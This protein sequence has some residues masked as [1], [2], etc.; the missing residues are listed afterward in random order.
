MARRR[1][2]ITGLGAVTSLGQDVPTL[3]KNILDG[4]SG[5]APIGA[6]DASQHA[7]RIASEVRGFDPTQWMDPREAKRQDRF[8]QFAMA[9][10]VQAVE[11]SG[12]D[13]AKEDVQRVGVLIGT[14]IG[15]IGELEQQHSRLLEGGPRRVS[16]FLIPKL[17]GNAASGVVSIRWGLQGPNSTVVTACA[18]A[19]HSL[20]A[21]LRCIQYDEADMMISGG[22]EAAI[23]ALGVAGF[24]SM[25][26]LSTRNDD[27][28][29]ASRPFDKDRDGFVIAEGAGVVV[30]EELEHAK[31]RGASIYAEVAGFAATGDAYH[32]TAPQP[33]GTGAAMAMI[34]ALHDAGI[35]PD[36]VDYINAHGTSTPLND[37]MESRAIRKALGGAADKVAVSS[38][39][40]MLGHM[41]GAAGGVEMIL[42]ALAVRDDVAPP[43]INYKTPDP[44][45]DLYYVPNEAKRMTIT[46]AMS[47]TLGFGGHNATLVLKKCDAGA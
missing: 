35:Q 47:N 15:G 8:A 24:A 40:S 46:Y 30:L 2:V 13:F 28:T 41:L 36:Q 19:N 3:W 45:C 31:R 1:V 22:S 12:I 9:A 38:T 33:E 18:S 25:L 16:P 44:D 10:A 27:P 4:R 14:G 34:R 6:F 42:T 21:A 11:D 39:K 5:V 17:M 37:A 26:A 43:T 29:A 23:T 20:G 7:S 32:I